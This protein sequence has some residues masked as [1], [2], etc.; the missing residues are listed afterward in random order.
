MG[1]TEERQRA[2]REI[3]VRRALPQPAHLRGQQQRVGRERHALLADAGCQAE[4][5]ATHDAGGVVELERRRRDLA[6]AQRLELEDQARRV[7]RRDL[8]DEPR[9]GLGV[10]EARAREIARIDADGHEVGVDLRGVAQLDLQLVE[11]AGAHHVRVDEGQREV[12]VAYDDRAL[13]AARHLDGPTRQTVE[14]AADL[15]VDDVAAFAHALDQELGLAG[16][17]WRKLV[18]VVVGACQCVGP[19]REHRLHLLAPRG[20]ARDAKRVVV[21]GLAW[22]E[23]RRAQDVA[24]DVVRAGRQQ[25]L[26]LELVYDE[27]RAVGRL[28]RDGDEYAEEMVEERD[29]AR[30]HDDARNG[31]DVVVGPLLLDQLDQER[32]DRDAGELEPRKLRPTR[33]VA[34]RVDHPRLT[35]YPGQRHEHGVVYF[36][37]PALGC[38]G[39]REVERLEALLVE[40][41]A[42]TANLVERE[43]PRRHVSDQQLLEHVDRDV[44]GGG[45]E[46]VLTL[47]LDADVLDEVAARQ[48]E[49]GQE[50]RVARRGADLEWLAEARAAHDGA[51]RG[52][53]REG[54][55]A[56]EVRVELGSD[57]AGNGEGVGGDLEGEAGEVVLHLGNGLC[58]SKRSQTEQRREHARPDHPRRAVTPRSPHPK[59]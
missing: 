28:V 59:T 49:G 5:A 20:R 51:D 9:G 3:D 54:V 53:R 24:H 42:E 27:R 43:R 45:V 4:A 25:D 52:A 12:R 44:G 8:L 37:H 11:L 36:D 33:P 21:L 10:D 29:V 16:A 34:G 32:L 46:D 14:H 7:A 22:H 19:G 2:E 57:A 17:L 38:E 56:G 6:G 31:G 23:R 13:G 47:D 40:L 15:D 55:G 48:R 41:D 30:D 39:Q 1:L 50:D 35:R 58:L 26:G 18:D